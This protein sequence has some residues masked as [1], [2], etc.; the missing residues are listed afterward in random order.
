MWNY[1][2]LLEQPLATCNN[3]ICCVTGVNVGGKTRISA[4]MLQNML[5]VFVA[6]ALFDH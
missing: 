4:E 5:V 3:L 2:L 1:S 6:Q